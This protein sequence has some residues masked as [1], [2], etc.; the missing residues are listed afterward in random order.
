MTFACLLFNAVA[1]RVNVSESS[2]TSRTFRPDKS[3][4]DRASLYYPSSPESARAA[5]GS[6]SGKPDRKRRT[7]TFTATLRADRSAMYFNQMARDR[8]AETESA[9]LARRRAVRLAKAI[10]NVRQK[11][12]LMP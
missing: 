8:Q 2:S 11:L 9:V 5:A 10:E 3:C 6:T 12:L 7:S 4:G 1:I